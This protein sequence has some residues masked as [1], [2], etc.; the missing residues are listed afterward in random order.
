MKNNKYTKGFVLGLVFI[1]VGIIIAATIIGVFTKGGIRSPEKPELI[2]RFE[3]NIK[4][5]EDLEEKA[6]EERSASREGTIDEKGRF[7]EKGCMIGGCSG[8]VCT[9]AGNDPITTCEF[10]PEYACYQEN[11][12]RCEVQ[13]DDKCGWT[14]NNELKQCLSNS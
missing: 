7:V 9:E 14:E 6:R 4:E 12:A 8:Q 2:D 5:V 13:S 11:F 10:R 1:I 3:E